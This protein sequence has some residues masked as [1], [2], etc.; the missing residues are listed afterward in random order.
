MRCTNCGGIILTNYGE[1]TCLMCA[2]PFD[3]QGR[4][5]VPVIAT[6]KPQYNKVGYRGRQGK[7]RQKV[8]YRKNW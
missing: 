3:E 6:E 8:I 7:Y 2:H 5:L 4:E 1:N